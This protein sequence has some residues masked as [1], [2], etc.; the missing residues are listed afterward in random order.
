MVTRQEAPII[1]PD[2]NST[3]GPTY[4]IKEKENHIHFTSASLKWTSVFLMNKKM[5]GLF[6]ANS[7]YVGIQQ[8]HFLF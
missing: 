8:G 6:F 7:A 1:Q 2:V 5:G 4:A 3:S